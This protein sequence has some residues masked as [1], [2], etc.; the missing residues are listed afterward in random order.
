MESKTT[1]IDHGLI[2]TPIVE[3]DHYVLGG[4]TGFLGKQILMPTGHG[5]GAYKPKAELQN[6]NG[7]ETMNCTNYGTNNCYET[8][9]QLKGF[10]DFPKDCSERYSGVHT[11]TTPFGND[12]HMVAEIIRKECGFVPEV[13]LPFTDDIATWNDYYTVMSAI[14]LLPFGKAILKRFLPGHEWVFN[15]REWSTTKLAKL[16]EALKYGPVAVSVHAWKDRNGFFFKEDADSDNHWLQ[17]LDFEEGKYWFVFDHY[18]QVEKKLEW[19]YNFF[20][21]K[22]YYLDRVAEQAPKSWWDKIVDAFAERGLFK[23]LGF[24]P[25]PV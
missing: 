16:K 3:E 5:W 10:T 8:L 21:A 17:L 1:E 13:D 24:D 25:L 20:A 22:V 6:K 14:W 4:Y 7:F 2:L 19:H 15:T 18:D 23:G 11:H 12:P 9:A